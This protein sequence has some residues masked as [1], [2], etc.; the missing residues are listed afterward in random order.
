[1]N[2]H[3]SYTAGLPIF[4]SSKTAFLGKRRLLA[5]AIILSIFI[6]CLFVFSF[7]VHCKYKS[8]PVV[9]SWLDI[10]DTNE[11]FLNTRKNNIQY[12][13]FLSGEAPSKEYFSKTLSDNYS[14]LLNN[15]RQ[16]GIL[17]KRSVAATQ[18]EKTILKENTEYIYVWEK[19][20]FL[21]SEKNEIIPYRIFVSSY[22]K[23]ILSFPEKLSSDSQETIALQEYIREASF[24]LNDKFYWTK[25]KGIVK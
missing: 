17:P 4:V 15:K 24:F 21:P 20:S 16:E 3:T 23:A 1:M 7:S 6:H 19:Q 22:G 13:S 11:L 18:N 10:I 5:L 12:T 9:Y 25:L 14:Y 2:N 8:T